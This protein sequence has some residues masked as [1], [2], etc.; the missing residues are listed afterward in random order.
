MKVTGSE[1][2]SRKWHISRVNVYKPPP[3]AYQAQRLAIG[4]VKMA[5]S[6]QVSAV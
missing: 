4:D 1:K 5:H 6:K 3:Q 2:P